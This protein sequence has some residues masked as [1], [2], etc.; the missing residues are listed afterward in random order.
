MSNI[1][2]FVKIVK[3]VKI[4]KIVQ[5]KF[6]Q[7]QNCKKKSKLSKMVSGHVSLSLWSKVSKVTGHRSV[8]LRT[9]PIWFLFGSNR[10]DL[11]SIWF[12]PNRFDFY[13]VQTETI[14]FRFGKWCVLKSG[15]I[16]MYFHNTS[17][18]MLK[19]MLPKVS[20]LTETFLTLKTREGF[21]FCVSPFMSLQS[22][23][24]SANIATHLAFV[25]FL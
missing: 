15:N 11:I 12:Q 4:T 20:S 13:S 10:T 3:F 9:E 21:L 19:I 25:W 7:C 22:T 16:A 8:Y 23:S 6:K 14:W 24:C 5:Q 1:I 2:I 17:C 18:S